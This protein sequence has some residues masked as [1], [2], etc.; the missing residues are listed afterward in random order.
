MSQHNAEQK[1]FGAPEAADPG[2][3]GTIVVNRSAHSVPLVSTGAETRTLARPTRA[4]ALCFLNM[5]TDGG[6][7]TVTVTG[8]YNEDGDTTFVFSDVGQFALF[9]SFYDGT[10]YYWRKF[11]DYGLGNIAPADAAVLSTLSGLL[12]TAD[13]INRSSDVSTRLVVVPAATTTLTLTEALHE[14]K[15]LVLQSTGGLAITPIAATGSGGVYQ[16][17]VKTAI[18]GGNVTIDAKAGNASDIVSGRAYQLKVG[19]GETV[20][21]AGASD[22]LITINGT[23]LGGL[24]GD[25]IRMID[26]ATNLWYV[27]I[28]STA[29]GSVATP[30]SNH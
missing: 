28:D 27:F 11:S 9:V 18:S 4:Q 30:F 7:I 20:Y 14:G 12:A 26:V 6:D 2:N 19:T 10:N 1:M 8:G 3:A 21:A 15:I 24:K 23:T 29:S 22:N 17:V 13:E 5:R 16:F 25:Y